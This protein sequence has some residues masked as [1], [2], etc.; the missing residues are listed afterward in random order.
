[1]VTRTRLG[2]ITPADLGSS[3]REDFPGAP[4]GAPQPWG[5]V[6]AQAP[7]FKVYTPQNEYIA[8]CKLASDAAALA[9]LYGD[10][11]TVRNGH[12]ARNVVWREGSDK[13]RAAE[14]YDGAASVIYWRVDGRPHL[15]A[16][17]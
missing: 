16:R 9:A 7:Q 8:A 14:S 2:P 17:V 13:F 11:A 4:R 12:S 15:P 1:M 10:G 6:M 3:G 5:L